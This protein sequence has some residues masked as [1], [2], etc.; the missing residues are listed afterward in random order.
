MKPVLKRLG[1]VAA[2]PVL[3]AGI[4]GVTSV[5]VTA[6]ILH[7]ILATPVIYVATGKTVVDLNEIVDFWLKKDITSVRPTRA[8]QGED[9]TTVTGPSL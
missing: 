9:P 8:Q 6:Q 1:L 3:L 5:V 7:V 4:L 2:S